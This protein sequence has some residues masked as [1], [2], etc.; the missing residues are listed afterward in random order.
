M[1]LRLRALQTHLFLGSLAAWEAG[2]AMSSDLA[3]L[4]GSLLQDAGRLGWV[5][6]RGRFI[7]SRVER[8]VL[9]RI[10]WARLSGL[11]DEYPF[12][13]SLT[14]WRTYYRFLLEHAP[15]PGSETGRR[16]QALATLEVV[17][18]LEKR[19]PDYPGLLARGVLLY[20]HGAYAAADQALGAHLARHPEGPWRLRAQN[21]LAAARARSRPGAQLM[22]E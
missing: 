17:R 9:F 18:A 20:E 14:D 5:E 19:D 7:M 16:D 15:R 6:S 10:R 11:L 22:L 21:Y 12:A 8:E 2:G 4:G 13:P 3:E 1:L